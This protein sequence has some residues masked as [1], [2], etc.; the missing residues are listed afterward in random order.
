MLND[1]GDRIITFG[2]LQW[3]QRNNWRR[4]LQAMESAFHLEQTLSQSLL[5]LH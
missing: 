2:K 5:E 1:R 4:G 3:P